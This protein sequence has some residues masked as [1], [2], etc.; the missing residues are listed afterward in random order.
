LE[1]SEPSVPYLL[2]VI[3]KLNVQIKENAYSSTSNMSQIFNTNSNQYNQYN[4]EM[5]K[6][7]SNLQIENEQ[8]KMMKSNEGGKRDDILEQVSAI[9]ED[10][11]QSLK[12]TTVM[13]KK[14]K[15]ENEDLSRELKDLRGIKK[16]NAESRALKRENDRLLGLIDIE[17]QAV[18]AMRAKNKKSSEELLNTNAQIEK[19]RKENTKLKLRIKSLEMEVDVLKRRKNINP[20]LLN[21]DTKSVYSHRSNKSTKSNGSFKSR[22]SNVSL[23]LGNSGSKYSN[24]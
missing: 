18:V 22:G 7:L 9:K 20:N 3:N 10:I 15:K 12:K 19:S 6:E 14:L 13:N 5:K 16:E 8:L 1:W 17:K 2:N 11:A 4:L 24:A 21:D 23:K